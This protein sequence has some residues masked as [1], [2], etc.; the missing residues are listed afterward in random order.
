[1]KFGDE[2]QVLPQPQFQQLNHMATTDTSLKMNQLAAK[3]LK[4]AP[5]KQRAVDNAVAPNDLSLATRRYMERHEIL[6][7]TYLSNY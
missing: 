1:M 5:Q 6:Q 4:M 2:L 3:Y 7:G